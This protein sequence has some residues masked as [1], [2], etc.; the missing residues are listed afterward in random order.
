MRYRFNT[1]LFIFIVSST[2]YAEQA[3]DQNAVTSAEDA[4]GVTVGTESLGVYNNGNVR[5]FSPNAAGNYRI[6]GL[7]FDRQASINNRMQSGSSIRVG[8][9]AQGYAFPSPTGIID[10]H[11]KESGNESALIP[12]VTYG[13][14]G[15]YGIELDGKTSIIEDKLSVAAGTSAFENHFGNGGHASSA[16]FGIVPRWKP[17]PRVKVIFFAGSSFYFDETTPGT[18]I[19]DG[20]FFP[21]NIKRGHYP[22]PNW[23]ISDSTSTN[24]GTI[25][26]GVFGEWTVRMGRFYSQFDIETSYANLF[27]LSENGDLS[28]TIVAYPSSKSSSSSGEIRVSR[29]F[30]EGP[31]KHLLTASL[32][33]RTVDST[34]GGGDNA[35]FETNN[36]N[37]AINPTRPNFQFGLK[38]KDTI[39]QVTG[40]TSYGL[41]WDHIGQATLGLQRTSYSKEVNDP[42]APFSKKSNDLWLPSLSISAPITRNISFYT[43]YVKGVEDAG[44]A[45]SYASNGNQVLAAIQTKQ[46]DAGI[47][48][49]LGKQSNFILGYYDIV[50]PYLALSQSN[51]YG[52]L[53]K[54]VHQGFELSLTTTPVKDLTIVAGAV[55]SK[56]RV[57]DIISTSEAIGKRP[58]AQSDYIAQLSLDYNFPFLENMSL[59]ASINYQSSQAATVDNVMILPSYTTIDLGARYKF[60]I[61]N[62]P[63]KLRVL[64]TNLTNKYTY[65]VLGNGVYEPIDKLGVSASISTQF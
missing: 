60:K 41:V 22:G 21:N 42:D 2:C 38:T 7:Y 61:G 44:V 14:Y 35:N 11:L 6:E 27:K 8:S 49:K 40:A 24:L 13:A 48:W 12:K 25:A 62:T 20:K 3:V 23:A 9:A 47:Q 57:T 32:R 18:Y 54:E 53:G 29:S 1:G 64:A 65:V 31:R 26:K 30:D 56:P 43:S 63:I 51:H 17:D 15:T 52:N 58:V 5:G 45:P 46:W 4:F 39:K 33:D 16:S 19:T 10:I 59:D 37:D 55:L 28:R 36:I 34:Y 50:K